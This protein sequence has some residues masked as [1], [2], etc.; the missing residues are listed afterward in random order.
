MRSKVKVDSNTDRSLVPDWAFYRN[1]FPVIQ[2]FIYL[3]HAAIAPISLAVKEEVSRCMQKYCEYGIVCN[4][5]YLDAVEQTRE[6]AGRIIHAKP[7]EIAFV[8]NTTQGLLIAAHGIEWEKGDNVVIP[9]KEFPANVFPW[10]GLARKGV[11][12]KFVPL[13]EGR[14]TVKGIQK[15]VNQRTRAVSVSAVSFINGFRCNLKEI[16]EFCE[17]KRICFI[18]DAIQALGA[19]EVDVKEC[20]VD[21][22]SADSHKWLLGPQGV[23][24]A[25][26]SRKAL[27]TFRVSNMGWKSMVDEADHLRYD[28]RLKPGA[29][30]F[31]EGTL[32]IFGIIGLRRAL[33]M[34]LDIGLSDVH[35]RIRELTDLLV[36]GLEERGY[37]IRSSMRT[38]ERSGI[39]S[40]VHDKY[41]SEEVYQALFDANVVC[42][43]RDG[44]VRI[45]PHF[46]NN[47]EDIDEFMK[48][49]R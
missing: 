19:V 24:I 28:I 38:E 25:Y 21:L 1:Q 39:L 48:A 44:A 31:E 6:L 7:S 3:N 33:Q 20:H 8:K 11:E 29:A 5:D 36:T 12:V 17:E 10:F 22:L 18:V 40:F 32:N 9:E 46:Y 16:G 42:A 35:D 34:L 49:L 26:L 41:S 13:E 27:D 14:F 47:A 4:R 15:F 37:I 23:G 45:S 30:R 43:L 2:D